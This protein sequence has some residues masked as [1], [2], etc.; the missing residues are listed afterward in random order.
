MFFDPGNGEFAHAPTY[1]LVVSNVDDPI[2][3]RDPDTLFSGVYWNDPEPFSGGGGIHSYDVRITP[4]RVQFFHDPTTP[5]PCW[6]DIEI[7]IT[8]DDLTSPNAPVGV[9]YQKD[10]E[11]CS[12]T[13]R[14]TLGSLAYDNPDG[15]GNYYFW[16]ANLCQVAPVQ[17]TC[18]GWKE[19][20]VIAQPLVGSSWIPILIG[21]GFPCPPND[22]L[23]GFNYNSLQIEPEGWVQ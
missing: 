22:T 13:Y 8:S 10:F 4:L 21:T 9:F 19:G 20:F 23:L 3:T 5:C 6:D 7:E 16:Y 2:C 1:T 11:V 12:R 14:F 15:L 17:T 18:F